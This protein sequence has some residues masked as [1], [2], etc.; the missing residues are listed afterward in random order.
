M[1][2]IPVLI[3]FAA[4]LSLYISACNNSD[5][6]PEIRKDFS[7]GVIIIN[8]GNFMHSN[9]DL[10]H[11]SP[12]D[13]HITN[14]IFYTSNDGLTAGDVIQSFS[15]AD[16]YGYFTANNS[17]TLTKVSLQDFKFIERLD[18]L[19]YPRYIVNDTTGYAYM[20]E[21]KLPGKLLKINTGTME[22]EASTDLGSQP[23]NLLLTDTHILC[24]NGAWGTDST[25]SIINKSDMSTLQTLTVGDGATDITFDAEGKIWVLCSGKSVYDENWH[26]IEESPSQ[27]VCLD[28]E[29]FDILKR[30]EIGQLGDAFQPSRLA[31]SP[32]SD[33]IYVAE[34]EKVLRINTKT[35]AVSDFAEGNFYGLELN[36]YSGNIYVFSDAGFQSNGYFKIFDTE[37]NPLTQ[38]IETGVGPNGAFF[39][40]PTKSHEY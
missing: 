9:G 31:G 7:T 33:Y 6:N 29:N 34:A 18:G 24:C 30:I 12:S 16:S 17:K 14:N 27:V 5:P 8:E 2:L 25:I 36:P 11:Y 4:I 28:P 39:L 19:Q 22:I 15:A 13:K 37:G 35:G 3:C 20:T 10:S 23:E 26:L 1:K 32:N 40:Y 21:G 38:E